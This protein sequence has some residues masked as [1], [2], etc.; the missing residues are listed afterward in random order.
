M[1][2]SGSTEVHIFRLALKSNNGGVAPHENNFESEP[3]WIAKTLRNRRAMADPLVGA[4]EKLHIS[5]NSA[6][7]DED[8][9]IDQI[10]DSQRPRKRAKQDPETLKRELERKYLTPSPSFSTPWLNKLQQSVQPISFF[11]HLH[12][13]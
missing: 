11:T 2:N 9:W 12:L 1:K 8:D 5:T 7:D 6:P 3:L 10:L 13:D 4:L